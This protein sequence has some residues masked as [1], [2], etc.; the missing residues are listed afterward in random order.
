MRKQ[1]GRREQGSVCP[2]SICQLA[3]QLGNNT[4]ISARPRPTNGNSTL[5][6]SHTGPQR[7]KCVQR[8]PDRGCV[9]WSGPH[10][11]RKAGFIYQTCCTSAL[12]LCTCCRTSITYLVGLVHEMN[13][14]RNHVCKY[15]AQGL[16][17]GRAS[18][19]AE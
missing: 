13:I 7:T 2:R 1:A 10:R 5:G 17:P 16:A 8:T 18:I 19:K 6:N 11:V 14:K 15:L 4:C 12:K 9:P 3:S